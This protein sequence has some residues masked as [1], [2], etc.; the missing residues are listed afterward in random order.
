MATPATLESP[1]KIVVCKV[2][3]KQRK[4]MNQSHDWLQILVVQ[5]NLSKA[6]TNGAK[7]SVRFI[8]VSAL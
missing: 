8:E 7:K 3:K 5:W 2:Y 6:D 4:L 1:V